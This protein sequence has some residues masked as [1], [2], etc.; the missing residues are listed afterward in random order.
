MKNDECISFKESL[1]NIVNSLIVHSISDIDKFELINKC[2]TPAELRNAI[3]RIGKEDSSI[4]SRNDLEYT[5]NIASGIARGLYVSNLIT[6]K[7]GIRQQAIYIYRKQD[8]VS[9]FDPR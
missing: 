7:Y 2:E 4:L 3:L 8:E 9:S 5:A 6:K 1:N